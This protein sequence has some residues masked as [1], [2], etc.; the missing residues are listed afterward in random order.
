MNRIRS[1]LLQDNAKPQTIKYP[2]QKVM[3]LGIQFLIHLSC[4]QTFP[5]LCIN[6]S[7]ISVQI[8][9]FKIVTE[10]LAKMC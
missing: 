7:Q 6:F 8:Q 10:L 9:R 2:W 5:L 4:P 1:F 3:Q